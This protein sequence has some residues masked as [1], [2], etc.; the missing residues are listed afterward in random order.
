MYLYNKKKMKLNFIINN[1]LRNFS[2]K[3]NSFLNKFAFARYF[4]VFIKTQNTPNPNFI[5]FLPGTQVM[6]GTYDIPNLRQ[7]LV[8]PLAKQLFEVFYI[9]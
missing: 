8:S 7:A 1:K 2:Y 3:K 6:D 5:K 9:I 4:S